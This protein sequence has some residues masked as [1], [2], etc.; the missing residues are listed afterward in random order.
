LLGERAA[1]AE[2]VFPALRYSAMTNIHLA[3]WMIAAGITRPITFHALR[4]TYA[5]LQL[6]FGADIFT[7]SKMLGHKDVK[8]TEI[9]AHLIDE[10]KRATTNKIKLK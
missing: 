8:T 3:R 1:D 10:K 9:Y 6:T 4:H 7:V 5:S 2:R